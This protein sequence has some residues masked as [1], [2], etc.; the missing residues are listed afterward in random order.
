MQSRRFALVW[1]LVSVLVCGWPLAAAAN[2]IAMGTA[3]AVQVPETLHVQVSYGCIDDF[4]GMFESDGYAISRDG[5]PFTAVWHGPTTIRLNPGSGL[6]TASVLQ[7]CDCEVP[8]GLHTYEITLPAGQDAC[9]PTTLG[10]TVTDPPPGPPEPWVEPNPDDYAENPWDIPEPPWPKGVDCAAVCDTPP[11][12]PEASD[13]ATPRID[14]GT[15]PPPDTG[16]APRP[17]A[18]TVP[19]PDAGTAPPMDAIPH[20]TGT[21]GGAET[22][23]PGDPSADVPGDGDEADCAAGGG[24][25]TGPLMLLA[26]VLLVGALALRRRRALT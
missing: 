20:D 26:A 14:A 6:G 12:P 10:L 4:G 23:P 19:R 11:P 25:P 9:A 2:P 1:S 15:P 16:T 21:A 13:A 5:V 17:D 7:V 3:T 22:A 8:A 24:A 18:G